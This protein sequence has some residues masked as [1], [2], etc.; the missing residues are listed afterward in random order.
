LIAPGALPTTDAVAPES[1]AAPTSET[2]A[3]TVAT[4]FPPSSAAELADIVWATNV[5]DPPIGSPEA[6][7]GGTFHT[8]L[9]SYP[10]T[11]RQ[12]GPNSNDVFAGWNR[13]FSLDFT[14]TRLHPNTDRF[15]PWMCT[16]WSIQDDH[17][18][19]Y[20]K[21][22]RDARWSD[23]EPITARDYVFAYEMM[24][25]EKIVDPW[26][27]NYYSSQFERVEAIDDY[28]LKVVGKFE[29]WRPLLDFALFPMP[30]HS[31]TIDADW[32][33]RTNLEP[34]IVAGP[35]TITEM[36]TGE[37]VVFERIQDWWGNDKHYF[38]G[39]YNPAKIHIAVIPSADRAFDFF[40]KGELSYLRVSTSR[41]WAEEMEFDAVKKGWVH[42]KRVF[43]DYPQGMYGMALNLA[44]PIFQNKDFR[45]AIQYLFDFDS[46]NSKLMYN[47]Y[48][49]AISAFEG[50][51][52]ANLDLIPYGF[53]PFKAR[54]H[55][56]KAGYKHR[57]KDGILVRDDGT[58]ATFTLTFGSKGLERHF[59]VIQQMY[60]YFGVDMQ[61]NLLEPGTAFEHGLERQYE[62][63]IMSRTTGYY[64]APWQYFHSVFKE[65]T[66]NNN[67]WYFGTAHTDSL[68]DVYRFGMNRNERLKAMHEL[69][70]IIQDEAFYVPFWYGPFVRFAYYDQVC[71][72]KNFVPKRYE[73]ITDWLVLWIDEER[74]N[75]LNAARAAG[76]DLP[77]D[78]V[79]DVDPYGV[80][81]R[82]ER[83]ATGS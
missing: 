56:R 79:I 64:P 80:K 68:I 82:L 83:V 20:Y 73:Q 65:S 23:G 6:K 59:T 25:D 43:I 17:K 72:P 35:Y 58:R 60:R 78:P 75:R 69:D 49:R 32:I 26:A 77:Y 33:K 51:E 15:I 21:L 2:N 67:I 16:H 55:L 12:V 52:Y 29:S 42:R 40:V 37:Y 19:V 18:T 47:A 38:Q 14:L 22:D 27:N 39:L 41:R 7:R 53:D 11:F 10:L 61:L 28:T 50:S 36:K 31:T 71:W 8:Y 13:A 62:A 57:G 63:T 34:P 9:T 30:A 66:N 54:E 1:P 70:A 74:E 45:K 48:Y 46:V 5:D 76:Q 3:P 24:I 4:T 44:K 81:A